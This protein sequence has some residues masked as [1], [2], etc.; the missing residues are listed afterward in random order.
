MDN[1]GIKNC[2]DEL[3]NQISKIIQGELIDLYGS[4]GYKSIIQTMTK[5]TS[6]L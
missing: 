5:I 3:D 4:K 1:L 2:S 6:F